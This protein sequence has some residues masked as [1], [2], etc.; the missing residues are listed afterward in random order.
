MLG[1]SIRPALRLAASPRTLARNGAPGVQDRRQS[2]SDGKER[3]AALQWDTVTPL[4][5]GAE[6]A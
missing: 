3:M 1:A 6:C 4:L 5:M 2:L